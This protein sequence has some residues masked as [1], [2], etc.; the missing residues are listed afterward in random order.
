MF[1]D[2]F[3]YALGKYLSEH[4]QKITYIRDIGLGFHPQFVRE[5]RPRIVIQEMAERF[6][7][8]LPPANPSELAA[9]KVDR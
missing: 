9:I 7:Q 1:R 6:L 5:V 8:I 3:G 4:F 2:S